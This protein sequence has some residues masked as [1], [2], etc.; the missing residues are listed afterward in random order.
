MLSVV[1]PVSKMSGRLGNMTYWL[2]KADRFDIEVIIVHDFRDQETQD[3]ISAIIS[4]LKP[5]K[6]F[7]VN[8]VYGSPGLA[9]NEGLKRSSGKWVAFW[10]S[11]DLPNLEKTFQVLNEESDSQQD[12]IVF[13]FC[14]VNEI[15]GSRKLCEFTND[16]LLDLALTP[17]IWRFLFKKSSLNGLEFSNLRIGEDQLFLGMYNLETREI[18]YTHNANYEYFYGGNGHQTKNKKARTDISRLAASTSALIHGSTNPRFLELQFARQVLSG[19]KMLNFRTGSQILFEVGKI[20]KSTSPQNHIQIY[21][22]FAKI[23]FTDRKI[24]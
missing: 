7:V 21:R 5:R 2:R 16:P 20:L 10:D 1:V 24:L 18:M 17:G 12:C 6:V 11:D 4:N 15:T 3:E 22:A 23:I 13:N 14:A 19:L 9:R 8:G